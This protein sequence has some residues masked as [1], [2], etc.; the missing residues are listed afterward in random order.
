MCRLRTV[1]DY[2]IDLHTKKSKS[3]EF[4]YIFVGGLPAWI[5]MISLIVVDLN[6]KKQQ[7]MSIDPDD[8]KEHY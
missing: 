5:W 1:L 2:H 7:E 8:G 3:I 4:V 6:S